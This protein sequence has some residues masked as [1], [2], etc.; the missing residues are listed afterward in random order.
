MTTPIETLA[1]FT[2]AAATRS[3][4]W[5]TKLDALGVAPRST[6][7]LARHQF[8]AAADKATIPAV[9]TEDRLWSAVFTTGKIVAGRKVPGVATIDRRDRPAGLTHLTVTLP[10]PFTAQELAKA[11]RNACDAQCEAALKRYTIE[12]AT[13]LS[14]IEGLP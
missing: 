8:N 11:L 12:R 14:R 2:E 4:E 6:L 7:R 10:C 9:I 13:I 5:V 1:A 3:V